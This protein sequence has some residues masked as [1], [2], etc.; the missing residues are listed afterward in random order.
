MPTVT[1]VNM[2]LYAFGLG[3][4]VAL[5][6]LNNVENYLFPYNHSLIDSVR[7]RVVINSPPLDL[8]PVRDD[9]LDNAERGGGTVYHEW[10]LALYTPALLQWRNVVFA[11]GAT[12]STAVT[13][14]T[15]DEFGVYARYNCWAIQPSRARGDI[16][17]TPGQR[18]FTRLRQ[19]FSDLLASS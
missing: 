6:S 4:N 9:T 2:A 8:F 11:S 17:I 3:W 18:G 15:R 7:H 16:A 14:Y 12:V 19:R 1:G 13:I 10:N 5:A